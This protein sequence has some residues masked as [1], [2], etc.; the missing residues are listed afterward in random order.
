MREDENHSQLEVPM[1]LSAY[2]ASTELLDC[3]G[4]VTH[5]LTLLP[6]GMVQVVIGSVTAV[7]DPGARSVVKPPGF[8]VPEQVLDHAGL[9]AR[10]AF[11]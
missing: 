9:L 5:T 4:R 2:L 7:V 3:S 6:A 1:D 10:D 11:G 8:R